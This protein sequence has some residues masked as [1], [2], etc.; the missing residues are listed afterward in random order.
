M[1]DAMN[2]VWKFVKHNDVREELSIIANI[3]DQHW[4]HGILSQIDWIHKNIDSEDIH[5]MGF[6]NDSSE[7]VAYMAIMNVEAIISN[8]SFS[9]LGFSNVCVDKRFTKEGIGSRL[10]TQAN[11]YIIENNKTGILL[12][13]D[14]LVGFYEK[15]GWNLLVYKEAYIKDSPYEKNVMLFNEPSMPNG[16]SI[17]ISKNF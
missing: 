15:N 8:L 13:R 7:L 1:V 16:C 14:S 9:F 11:K 2:I 12:C 6:D 17:R 4:T 5:L 10:V 3:K